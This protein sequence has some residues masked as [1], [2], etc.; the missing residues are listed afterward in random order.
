MMFSCE[1]NS[2]LLLF[3]FF[4]NEFTRNIGMHPTLT[5]LF[6]TVGTTWQ[7]SVNDLTTSGLE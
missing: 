6:C 5:L 7:T 1:K 3:T 2:D 4:G